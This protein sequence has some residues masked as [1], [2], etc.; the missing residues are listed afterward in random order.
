VRLQEIFSKTSP[1]QATS[2]ADS[3]GGAFSIGLECG[4]SHGVAH[5][6]NLHGDIRGNLAHAWI[7]S[8]CRDGRDVRVRRS[9]MIDF[10]RVS[11][12]TLGVGKWFMEDPVAQTYLFEE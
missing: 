8:Q 10:G 11:E 5:G 7:E 3:F 4:L 1:C 2:G 9:T 6:Q 12:E